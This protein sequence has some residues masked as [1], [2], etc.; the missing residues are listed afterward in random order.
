MNLLKWLFYRDSSEILDEPYQSEI[1]KLLDTNNAMQRGRLY[2][3]DD[4][5]VVGIEPDYEGVGKPR[6]KLVQGEAA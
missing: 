3:L 4:S 2:R 6:L 5:G 1:Q